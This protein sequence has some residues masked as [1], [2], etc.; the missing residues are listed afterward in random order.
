MGIQEQQY[1]QLIEQ[2][3][4]AAEQL[5]VATW[6]YDIKTGKVSHML[7][8]GSVFG[9]KYF[10]GKLPEEVVE[11]GWID[12]EDVELYLK[13]YQKIQN[14]EKQAEVEVR[15][16]HVES[17]ELRWIRQS[18]ITI[19]DEEDKPI[20]A[21]GTAKDIT[22]QKR[23]RMHI[24]KAYENA[25]N[26]DEKVISVAIFNLTKGIVLRH[27]PKEGLV[28]KRERGSDVYQ[29][30][31]EISASI[32][33]EERRREWVRLHDRRFLLDYYKEGKDWLEIEVER[34]DMQG[35]CY[36]LRHSIKVLQD[37][38]TSDILALEYV[39]NLHEERY[40]KKIMKRIIETEYEMMGVIDIEKESFVYVLKKDKMST[41]ARQDEPY[42][43]VL[44]KTARS[45]ISKEKYEDYKSVM[46]L[47]QVKRSLEQEKEYIQKFDLQ[48]GDEVLRRYWKF[49]YLDDTRKYLLVMRGI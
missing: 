10:Y 3:Q 31:H 8:L 11:N 36:W 25:G 2:F 7:N 18:Y 6:K 9:Q 12:L 5:G 35:H 15:R 24:Y 34:K 47:E 42:I 41:I 21:I 30:I 48:V 27:R 29:M 46:S 40:T 19:F 14:G 20:Y 45:F 37:S 1:Q 13:F 49:T 44:D 32:P 38:Q 33:D 17:G 26:T 4:I 23:E 43:R 16:Y 39:H 28:K 22:A